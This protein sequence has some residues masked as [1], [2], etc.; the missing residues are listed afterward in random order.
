MLRLMCS[1]GKTSQQQLLLYADWLRGENSCPE[2][3]CYDTH[4]NRLLTAAN[5]PAMW[6]HRAKQSDKGH[7]GRLCSALYNNAFHVVGL[8]LP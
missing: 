5:R 2:A 3:M 8:P 7:S 1:G 6:D 4:R